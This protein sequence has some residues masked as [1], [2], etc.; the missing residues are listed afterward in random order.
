MPGWRPTRALR[1]VV[2]LVCLLL[3][4]AVALGRTDLVVLAV[5]LLT[6]TLWALRRTPEV[7]AEVTV[8][9]ADTQVGEGQQFDATVSVANPGRVRFVPV[10]VDVRVGGWLA[11][12]E[13][14]RP[15]VT[16]L[17]AERAIDVAVRLQARRWGRHRF[18]SVEVVAAACD[19]LLVNRP[20]PP[21]PLE[22]RVHP[23]NEHFEADDA[24]PRAAELAGTHRSRRPGE[25][26]EL[27]GVR[28]FVPGDRLRRIDWRVSLRTREL[29]VVATLSDRD[30][31]VV[32]LL[33]T[34]HEAGVSGGVNGAAS[35]LDVTVR[36]AASVAE[37]Y[38]HRGDRV[39]LLEFGPRHRQLRAAGGRLHYQVIR[40]WLL[41]TRVV[42]GALEPQDWLARP[43]QLPPNALIVAFTPLLDER[44]AE[45]LARMAW[46]G[47]FL[48]AVDTLPPRARPAIKSVWRE[49]AT[50]LW[51]LERQNTIDELR[52]HGVPV[53]AWRGSG[54]LDEVLRD[55]SRMALT[56]RPVSR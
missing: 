56:S 43:H 6:G 24:M 27:V 50:R 23:V 20:E 19:G 11:T 52:E 42:P 32:L 9:V 46:A 31:E 49:P 26:G 40:D 45:L 55:V 36:G 14:F 7:S 48:I 13:E 39:S 35:V 53:V 18:G 17:P 37:H 54:S 4:A 12:T 3:I 47:R 5:P 15:I 25:G 29:H 28:R 21:Q 10:S 16:A 8:D 33:D 1:R 34:L 38:L 41:D 22:V 2:G 51:L 44:S 30:A